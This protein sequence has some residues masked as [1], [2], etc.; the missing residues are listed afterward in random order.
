[1]NTLVSSISSISKN[2]QKILPQILNV[3]KS[4]WKNPE[5]RASKATIKKRIA[6]YSEGFVVVLIDNKIRAFSSS[7]IINF[8]K[9]KQ[10]SWFDLT[11][12]G[13]LKNHD[14]SGDTIWIVSMSVHPDF[15]SL[16]LGAKMLDFHKSNAKKLGKKLMVGT[17]PSGYANYKSFHNISIFEYTA[18]V[19]LQGYSID[20]KLRFYQKNGFTI[21]DLVSNYMPDPQSETWGCLLKT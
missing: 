4:V 18:L 8:D 11:D 16:G 7:V 9:D 15:Q 20:K 5:W 14:P 17:T 21:V 10:N 6:V 19:D 3:E 1:M 12:S 2:S 13:N